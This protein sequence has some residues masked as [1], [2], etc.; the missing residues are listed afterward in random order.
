MTEG[1]I[2]YTRCWTVPLAGGKEGFA[3]SGTLL[4]SGDALVWDMTGSFGVFKK[5]QFH[6][7]EEHEVGQLIKVETSVQRGSPEPAWDGVRLEF[8]V[9]GRETP[10]VCLGCT[11]D[12]QAMSLL[13]SLS[14]TVPIVENGQMW[15]AGQSDVRASAHPVVIAGPT[16]AV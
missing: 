15:Q 11:P 10:L 14:R 16:G 7:R 13:D 2:H 3:D 6:H 5:K 4:A 8:F 9:R 12:D 1:R